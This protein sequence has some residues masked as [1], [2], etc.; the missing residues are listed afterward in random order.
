MGREGSVLD[1]ARADAVRVYTMGCGMKN[2][3]I[4]QV[5]GSGFFKQEGALV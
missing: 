4:C 1:D 2:F 3:R 5:S